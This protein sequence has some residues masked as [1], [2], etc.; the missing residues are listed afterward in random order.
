[1]FGM[2][3]DNDSCSSVSASHALDLQGR[4][5]ARFQAY[6]FPTDRGKDGCTSRRTG[7]PLHA[8]ES[9]SVSLVELTTDG[10]VRGPESEPPGEYV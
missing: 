9:E 7:L 5:W 2:F 3:G 10:T 6:V 8:G 4:T 1:M